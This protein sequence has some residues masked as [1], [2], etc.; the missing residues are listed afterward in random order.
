[1]AAP[2][3]RRSRRERERAF[4]QQI[5]LEAAEDVFAEHGFQAASVEQIAARSE[6]AI[7]TLYKTFGSKEEIFAAMVGH[8]Q[9]EFLRRIERALGDEGAAQGRLQR[10]VGEVF[11][12]FDEH[13]DAFRLYLGA[14]QGFPWHIRSS[15]GER[16]FARYGEFIG[17]VSELLAAGMEAGDWPAADAGRLAAAVAGAINGL[18]TL[19]HTTGAERDL[20]E[21]IRDAEGLILRMVG[22][23]LASGRAARSARA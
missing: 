3:P 6:V 17:F 9:E 13:Q 23:G 18:L 19:R 1:M 5:I 12:Y 10:L 16:A 4:R 22:A 15:L 14:T 2:L 21:E 11:R 7:A 20:A 8:R